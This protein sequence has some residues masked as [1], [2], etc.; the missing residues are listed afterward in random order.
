M[1]G[2]KPGSLDRVIIS[3]SDSEI[4]ITDSKALF[5]QILE[6]NRRHFAQNGTDKTPFTAPPLSDIIN[7]F[8]Y[9]SKTANNILSGNLHQFP[10]LPEPIQILLKNIK[11]PSKMTIIPDTI[12]SEEFIKGIKRIPEKK[13]LHTQE[14]ITVSIVLCPYTLTPLQ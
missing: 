3:T 14:E 12:S 7:P 4:E 11:A 1:K 5:K 13:L 10:N 9:H 8:Q 2:C 6:Q